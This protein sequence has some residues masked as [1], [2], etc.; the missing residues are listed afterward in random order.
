MLQ[1]LNG[2][3]KLW[4]LYQKIFIPRLQEAVLC[5]LMAGATDMEFLAKILQLSRAQQFLPIQ[6]ALVL[7]FY[8]KFQ[9]KDFISRYDLYRIA[10]FR[11]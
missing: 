2:F 1:E 11:M 3:M 7:Q 10:Y 4:L 9:I 5:W 6:W 8:D